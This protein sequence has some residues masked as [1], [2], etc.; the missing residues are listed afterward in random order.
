MEEGQS[1]RENARER[2]GESKKSARSAATTSTTSTATSTLKLASPKEVEISVQ[3]G[4]ERGR[5]ERARKRESCSNLASSDLKPVLQCTQR[6]VRCHWKLNKL[7]LDDVSTKAK[8]GESPAMKACQ[9]KGKAVKKQRE[10]G[11]MKGDLLP[12]SHNI[13]GAAS[14]PGRGLCVRYDNSN[15]SSNNSNCCYCCCC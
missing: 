5:G 7:K 14:V 9:G 3:R 15:G 11:V 4:R 6:F 12:R 13:T 2:E 10:E 1:E 8:S